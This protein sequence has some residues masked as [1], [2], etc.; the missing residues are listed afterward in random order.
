MGKPEDARTFPQLI[1]AAAATYG[2]AVAVR[3]EG[4]DGQDE[5]ITFADLERQSADLARGLLARGVGKGSRVGFVYGNG[6]GFA[7]MLA[8]TAR[9][10]AVAV[11]I[12][13]MIRAGELV[14]VLRQSDIGGLIVQRRFMGYDYAERLAE[15]LP[16]LG[17]AGSGPLAL[18]EVPFLR[19]VASTGQGLPARMIDLAAITGDA[20]MV[21]EDV[22]LQVESEVHLA[23]QMVEIYTS[24]SMALPKG[25][26]HNHGPVLFRTGYLRGMLSIERGKDVTAQ[27]PMFWIGGLMMY[28]MPALQAGATCVCPGKTLNNSR[29]AMGSVLTEDDLAML[30]KAPKPWWGLGMSETLGPYSYAGDEFRAPGRPLC[31]PLD[32]F[33]DGYDIRIADENNQP[34]PDG[35]IGEMQVRGYPVTP[36]LHKIERATYFTPDGYYRTGDMCEVDGNRVHF[37]GRDGDMIKTAGSNVSPAEVE[38]ELMALNGIEAAY[39]FGVPDHDRGQIVVAAVIAAE[40]HSPDFGRVEAEMRRKLSGYKVPRRWVPITRADV[41]L[42]HSNKVARRELAELVKARLG[43]A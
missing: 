19:W 30:S 22:L 25:V 18:P 6:P 21:G 31:A 34:V 2:D 12:S 1:R 16:G 4:D 26:R 33:A 42:L 38:M 7:L 10:G 35:G 32:H 29:V 27:L 13:T 39:V 28:L 43:A 5:T 15:A 24:G 3:A 9:I 40:G 37:V 8:A 17:E 23:D 20:G 14:R 36:G 41:P 11:P